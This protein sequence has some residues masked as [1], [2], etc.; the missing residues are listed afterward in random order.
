MKFSAMMVTQDAQAEE[1]EGI[2]FYYATGA[3]FT[4]VARQAF[5]PLLDEGSTIH[6]LL[7]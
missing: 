6:K 1:V 7:F 4:K 5:N 3:A 2:V